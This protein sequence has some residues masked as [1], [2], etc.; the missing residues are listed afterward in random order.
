M[1]IRGWVFRERLVGAGT[2]WVR[3]TRY[4]TWYSAMPSNG[5]TGG[6][7][8]LLT[9]RPFVPVHTE[10]MD[11]HVPS[12]ID[13]LCPPPPHTPT[14]IHTQLTARS[15]AAP[16][17]CPPA[18]LRAAEWQLA[19]HGAAARGLRRGRMRRRAGAGR[20]LSARAHRGRW[21]APAALQRAAAHA[22]LHTR[23]GGCSDAIMHPGHAPRQPSRACRSWLPM[24]CACVGFRR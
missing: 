19:L 9:G 2:A 12:I 24:L 7:A 15:C 21:R 11:W 5:D 16:A 10:E 18:F 3:T 22:L 14:H 23:C 17:P 1:G 8:L 4:T 6:D 20:P 13:V